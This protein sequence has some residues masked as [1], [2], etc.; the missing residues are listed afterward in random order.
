MA[1]FSSANV[2]TGSFMAPASGTVVV[3]VSCVIT[4]ATANTNY[5][6][7]LAAHGTTIAAAVQHGHLRDQFGGIR[8]S[9]TSSR[10]SSAA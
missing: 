1:A 3:T 8:S 6:L 7:A 9:R 5:S 10:S 4:M 2:N